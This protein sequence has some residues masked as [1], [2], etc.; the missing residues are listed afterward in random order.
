MRRILL[1]IMFTF[2]AGLITPQSNHVVQVSNF[3]FTPKD[4]TI[5]LGD[6]VTWNWVEGTHTTTSDSTAGTNVWNSVI[7]QSNQEFSFVLK[8]LGLHRYY[9]IP[10]GAPGGSGMAGTI[11]VDDIVPVELISFTAKL[12]EDIIQLSWETATE[13][14]NMGFDIERRIDK[15]EWVKIGFIKGYGT[16]SLRRSYTFDD[17]DLIQQGKYSYRL[18]QQDFNGSYKYYR[19]GSINYRKE[20]KYELLQNYPNPFNPE[21]AIR[22]AVP[23]TSFIT[24]RVYN[25]LGQE[26]AELFSGHLERGVHEFRFIAGEIISGIYLYKVEAKGEDGSTYADTRKMTLLK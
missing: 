21:T 15:S 25:L 17:P 22:V 19:S 11:Q 12:R 23:V 4:L 20:W 6:T 16:S 8:S 18:K 24:V 14:N 26:I 1:L 7:G 9:C 2:L 10:H 5:T 3:I 13:L